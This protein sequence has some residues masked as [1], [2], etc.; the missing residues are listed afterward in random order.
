MSSVLVLKR[1][2]L[3]GGILAAAIAII[4]SILGGLVAGAAGVASALVGTGMAVVFLGITAVSI[5]FARKFDIGAFFGI[6]MG[7]WLLKFV[8]FLVL[9]FALKDQPWIQDTVLFI[10]IVAAVVGTL[11]VDVI[12]AAKS[13]VPYVE[14]ELP[15]QPD[16]PELSQH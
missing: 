8:L 4:G 1:A 16:D 11:A 12:V 2:L 15:E 9:A 13:R 3:Y 7:A 10:T 5:L 14:T 6:V